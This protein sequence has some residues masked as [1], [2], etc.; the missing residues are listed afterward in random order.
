MIDM[1]VF[2][3]FLILVYF[4]FV[5][6][7]SSIFSY[8]AVFY[9]VI[10]IMLYVV[11][12]H[13]LYCFNTFIII[14]S[15]SFSIILLSALIVLL[16]LWSRYRVV[17]FRDY[18]WLFNFLLVTLFVVLLVTFRVNRIL[19]F[20][21]FF[22][23]SIIPTLLII[24]GWGYQ[25]ERIQAGLYFIFYTL[26]SSLPLLIVIMWVVRTFLRSNFFLLLSQFCLSGVGGFMGLVLG[27][28]GVM[29]FIVKLPVFFFHL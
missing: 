11:G 15:V 24:V 12:N 26:I 7:E 28:L 22:E 16:M 3:L 8:R 1:V 5:A 2:R 9:L 6:G 25:T 10:V 20:Y 17:L 18:R 19:C 14:D 27:L 4:F 29:A 13:Y 23:I 21:F